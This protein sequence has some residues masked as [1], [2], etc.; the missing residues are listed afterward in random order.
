MA[1]EIS[2][3]CAPNENGDKGDDQDREDNVGD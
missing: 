1:G 2:L 3:E